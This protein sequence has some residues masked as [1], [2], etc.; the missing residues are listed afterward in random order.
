[1]RSHGATGVP[2]D[3]KSHCRVRDV[4]L[5]RVWFSDGSSDFDSLLHPLGCFSYV[6]V[7]AAIAFVLQV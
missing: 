5:L 2:S 6:F 3:E 4:V 1:M 7:T